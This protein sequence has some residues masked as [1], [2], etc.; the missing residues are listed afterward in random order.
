MFRQ[1]SLSITLRSLWPGNMMSMIATSYL[2]ANTMDNFWSPLSICAI[3]KPVLFIPL[4][5]NKEIFSSSLINRYGYICL[6]C[7]PKMKLWFCG[8]TYPQVKFCPKAC[9]KWILNN[10]YDWYSCF[11]LSSLKVPSFG[12]RSS[13]TKARNNNGCFCTF[14]QSERTN[15]H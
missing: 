10:L 14:A 12:A 4:I 3:K 15:T 13:I 5:I 8:G 2:T 9:K 7:L 1:R 6:F 11:S